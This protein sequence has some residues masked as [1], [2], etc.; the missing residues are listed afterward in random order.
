MWSQDELLDTLL[1]EEEAAAPE[2]K[3]LTHREPSA[4]AR[5][6]PNKRGFLRLVTEPTPALK[7]RRKSEPPPPPASPVQVVPPPPPEPPRGPVQ[8]SLFDP[9]EG[10]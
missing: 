2:A 8:L 5:P 9:P 6:L 7:Q 3:P 1:A 10:S 4:P